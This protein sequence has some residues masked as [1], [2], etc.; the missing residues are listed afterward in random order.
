[1]QL[2]HFKV[3]WCSAFLDWL[4]TV[5]RTHRNCP[6]SCVERSS[7]AP[8]CGWYRVYD[9]RARRGRDLESITSFYQHVRQTWLSSGSVWVKRR[10]PEEKMWKAEGWVWE[11][12][13]WQSHSY[14][15][16]VITYGFGRPTLWT[17]KARLLSIM[18]RSHLLRWPRGVIK[19]KLGWFTLWEGRKIMSRF[20]KDVN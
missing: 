20:L 14:R 13:S 6:A 11:M 3:W 15:S 1:M 2:L 8:G 10:K 7:W 19:F 18:I 4:V 5:K 17:L 9:F 16:A 12:I